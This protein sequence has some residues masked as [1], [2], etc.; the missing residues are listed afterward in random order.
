MLFRSLG[1]IGFGVHD[2]EYYQGT[3]FYKPKGADSSEYK[4]YGSGWIYNSY[5][6]MLLIVPQFGFGWIFNNIDLTLF[7]SVPFADFTKSK[8]YVEFLVGFAI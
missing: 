8:F 7:A 6:S 4:S 3:V 5:D 2:G 1:G